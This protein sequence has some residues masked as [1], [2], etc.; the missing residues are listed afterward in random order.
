MS[1]RSRL[2]ITTRQ[3]EALVA[4]LKNNKENLAENRKL[5]QNEAGIVGRK[6]MDKL[7]IVVY[8]MSLCVNWALFGTRGPLKR[9][10]MNEL[11]T[12]FCSTSPLKAPNRLKFLKLA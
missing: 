9:S 7:K 4:F 3:L 6:Q 10:F 1:V 2:R 8:L 5:L 12:F 11:N